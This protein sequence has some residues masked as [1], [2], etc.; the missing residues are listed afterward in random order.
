ML[1]IRPW[2]SASHHAEKECEGLSWEQTLG[3]TG[4]GLQRE[5]SIKCNFI[6]ARGKSL[7]V[8]HVIGQRRTMA[9]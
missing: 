9:L 2:A 5:Q 4:Q 6:R 7:K 1:A 8:P 3:K